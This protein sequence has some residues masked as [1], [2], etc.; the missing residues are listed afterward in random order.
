[1][2]P[3]CAIVTN[4]KVVNENVPA[5]N[6]ATISYSYIE[7]FVC[8]CLSAETS[9]NDNVLFHAATALRDALIRDWPSLSFSQIKSV[10][11]YLMDFVV[12]RLR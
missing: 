9:R 1:M 12:Q 6:A 8:V 7:L 4:S 5:S 3:L 11:I 2:P 10:H